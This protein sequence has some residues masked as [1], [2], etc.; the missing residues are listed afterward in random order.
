MNITVTS[1]P[2]DVLQYGIL[3][4]GGLNRTTYLK[5]ILILFSVYFRI[6]ISSVLVIHRT[7]TKSYQFCL[8]VINSVK[9]SIQPTAFRFCYSC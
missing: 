3:A 8:T 2:D 7:E 4:F 1:V 5:A 6:K 9:E